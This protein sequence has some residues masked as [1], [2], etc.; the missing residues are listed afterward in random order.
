MLA[1]DADRHRIL[2]DLELQFY[3]ALAEEDALSG[4]YESDGE[5]L[6]Y[7]QG[8]RDVSVV[9]SNDRVAL[10]G[11]IASSAIRALG[12]EAAIT[13]WRSGADGTVDRVD[14]AP[15]IVHRL[16][17]GNWTVALDELLVATLYRARSAKLPNE[18]GEFFLGRMTWSTGRST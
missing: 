10:H 13:I 18:T 15:S 14:V 8:C 2:H 17:L 1:E 4:H 7:G 16:I 6:R 11:A 12:P 9:L 5:R 3:R